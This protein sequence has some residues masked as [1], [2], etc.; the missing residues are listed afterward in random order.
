MLQLR[1]L[2]TFYIPSGLQVS[3][4]KEQYFDLFP[5]CIFNSIPV[6]EPDG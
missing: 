6:G 4:S 5:S 3:D 1:A 2:V